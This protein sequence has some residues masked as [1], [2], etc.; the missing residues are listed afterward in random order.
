[1]QLLIISNE[2][3]GDVWFSKHHYAYE[4]SALGHRVY[5]VDPPGPWSFSHLWQWG[6]TEE[7]ITENLS[8]LRYKNPLPLRV[9]PRLFAAWNDRWNTRKLAKAIRHHS[10]LVW[11]FD[12]NRLVHWEGF[13]K[14]QRLYHVADP[15]MHHPHD[16]LLA[17]QSDLVVCTSPKYLAHYKQL[18]QRPLYIPHGISAEDAY[19]QTNQVQALRQ[20]YGAYVLLTG[21]I[22]QDVDLL[23]L[24]AA[25][26]A[27]YPL[28]LVGQVSPLVV[29]TLEWRSLLAN[30]AVHYIGPVHAKELKHYIAAARVCVAAYRF[31]LKK[32]IG[33]GSPLKVLHYLL[34]NKPVITTIDAEIP[35][36]EG[37]SIWRV[38]H[39]HA[40]LDM[41]AQLWIQPDLSESA[42]EQTQAYLAQHRYPLLIE[43][44]LLALQPQQ[45]EVPA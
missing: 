26:A 27:G 33:T 9:F 21:S 12:I 34:Q 30:T 23:L 7:R 45:K 13:T 4:L 22:N 35:S 2:A 6:V 32:A 15:Y 17:Q 1:M 28:L 5:F 43:R 31:D 29:D 40:F 38:H 25:A 37:L 39:S 11:Q 10:A 24:Q 36:L 14:L 20:Q 8:V 42:I 16:R 41:L 19:V 18:G 3:W 44:I